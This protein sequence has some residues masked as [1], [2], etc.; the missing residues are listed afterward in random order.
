MADHV[1]SDRANLGCASF[2]QLATK[3]IAALVPRFHAEIVAQ[4]VSLSCQIML[5]HITFYL[6]PLVHL[7]LVIVVPEIH[8]A[9]GV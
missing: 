3:A 7:L 2:C 5:L 8:S 6:L 1:V 4:Q 9:I